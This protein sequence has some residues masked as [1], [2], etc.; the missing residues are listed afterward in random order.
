MSNKQHLKTWLVA[1]IRS[2]KVFMTCDTQ[3]SKI[4]PA[5]R[6]PTI[7]ILI[8]CR[9]TL[10]LHGMLLATLTI[11]VDKAT[12][13]LL[14]PCCS[15]QINSCLHK[16]TGDDRYGRNGEFC[17]TAGPVTCSFRGQT[18]PSASEVSP[19]RLLSSGTHFHLTSA[20][21]STVADSSNQS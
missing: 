15:F 14:L 2:P 9:P 4:K 3:K 19:S 1:I 18:R 7:S 5:K 8:S 17:L 10:A 21:R 11:T 16:S 6:P 12:S 13:T 20:H